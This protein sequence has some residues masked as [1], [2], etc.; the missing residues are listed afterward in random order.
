[1]EKGKSAPQ[2]V[3]ISLKKL[4]LNPKS[5]R[6]IPYLHSSKLR[7]EKKKPPSLVSL[8]LGVVGRHLEDIIEDLSE[9]AVNFPADIKIALAAI[10]RRRKLL[11]DDVLMSLADSSWEILDL[12]GSD[13]SDFGLTKVAKLCCSLRAVDISQC[14]NITANGVSELVQHCHSLETLRCGGCPS[15]ES[16]ARRCLGIL[17]PKLNDV[18]GDSWEELDTMEIGHGAQ[19]LRWLVWPKIDEDSIEMMSAECPRIIVN[20]KPS[21][22]GFK[23]TEVPRNAFPDVALDDLFVKDI[24][25]KTW[26]ISRSTPKAIS[27]SLPSANELSIAEKFRLAFVERDTRLAPKR[28][29]NARQHQRRLEREWVTTSTQAKALALASRATKS[30]HSRN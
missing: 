30:L 27:Q 1:M 4:D 13:V 16:T 18:E 22:F 20:P 11:S 7:F 12:S 8:C 9:I 29:K 26:S 15:S 21:L 25:P 23:G 19:S 10:A 14:K 24:D 17:K 3:E 28:A 2:A 5:P 6:L